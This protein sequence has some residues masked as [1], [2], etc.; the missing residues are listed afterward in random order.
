M[1]APAGGNGGTALGGDNMG[2][3]GG[4]NAFGEN[5]YYFRF[6]PKGTGTVTGIQGKFIQ[7]IT[8]S[9]TGLYLVQ[10]T[11]N[12][13]NILGFFGIVQAV[14]GGALCG[15]DVQLDNSLVNLTAGTPGG[16]IGV[17]L[18]QSSTGNYVAATG[19]SNSQVFC[20]LI[21]S[22]NNTLVP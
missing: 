12:L 5:H 7:S 9:A 16:T 19:D 14:S 20:H 3:T 15:Y 22:T 10:F 1:G 2:E 21:V 13:G 17:A 4:S 11:C 18:T 8:Y 6:N